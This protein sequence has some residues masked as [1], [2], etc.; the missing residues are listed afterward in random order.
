MKV[1]FESLRLK[2]QL[3]REIFNKYLNTNYSE[4]DFTKLGVVEEFRNQCQ[5]LAQI[6]LMLTNNDFDWKDII[7]KHMMEF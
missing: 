1:I 4:D 2:Q 5:D 7:Q 6:V 3:Q